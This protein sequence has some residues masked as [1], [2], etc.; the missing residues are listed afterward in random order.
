MKKLT[1]MAFVFIAVT[2]LTAGTSSVFA[3]DKPAA[4]SSTTGSNSVNAAV[5][6]KDFEARKT[7]ILQHISDRLTKIQQIQ[8]CV[9][10]ANDFQALRAC[11]PHKD[12]TQ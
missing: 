10:A 8:S 1:S 5:S 12:K 2:A 11:R 7:M 3:Q 9:Q 6:P 4:V